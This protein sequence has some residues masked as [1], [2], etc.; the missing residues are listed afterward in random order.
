MTWQ[1]DESPFQL[2]HDGLQSR[3]IATGTLGVEER[4]PFVFSS[5]IAA[6]SP[7][8]HLVSATP[9][10]AGC[11]MGKSDHELELMQIANNATL[12]VYKGVYLA[13]H[14]GMTQEDAGDLITKAYAKV[15]FRGEASVETGEYTALPH[16]SLTPQVIR[17]GA[18]V[19]IDD[20]CLVEG[21]SSDITR[22]FVLGKPT[23]KMRR[24]FDVVHQAQAAALAAAKPGTPCEAVDAAAR[25]VIADAN[26]GP[27]YSHFYHRVGHGIG[28][29]GHEWP[30]LVRGNRLPLAARM[31]FSDEPGIYL[32]GEFGIR[33]E[34]DMYITPDGAR[35]FTGPSPSLEQ[36][37]L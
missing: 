32:R 30:Y 1:E 23:D 28:M 29:D 4:V 27:G 3:R 15:G 13:L 33:L 16:G 12:A 31:T 9:I 20:G 18:I 5:E 37:F 26:F 7:G 35:L 24:V 17:E 11:R 14:P 21:Y 6:A 19:M 2:V 8:L 36:P 34:D 10:T 25:K 22:T